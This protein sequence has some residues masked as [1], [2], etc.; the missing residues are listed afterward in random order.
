MPAMEDETEIMNAYTVIFDR[1]THLGPGDLAATKRLV[2][3][4]RPDLPP[5]L[6]VADFGC[7]VGASTLVLAEC[8][9]ES[10]VLALDS[11]APFI[12]RLETEA[13]EL[14]L[15]DRISAVVGDMAN[16]PPLDGVIGEFDLIWAESAIYNIGRAN[17]FACWR[18]LLKP[19]GWLVFSDIV[20]QCEPTDRSD[21]AAVFWAGEYPDMKTATGVMDELG[22]AGFSALDPVLVD[23]KAWS[24]YYEPLRE[25]LRLLRTKENPPQALETVIAE[26]EQ[27][28]DVYDCAGNE[29]AL[30]FFLARRAAK[31]NKGLE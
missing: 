13:D 25:R 31:S 17:A 11:H 20:W 5:A 4:L 8:L 15:G 27:E 14:G 23:R 16:P 28:I 26:L 22:S 19:D 1:L 9:P 30:A 10:R 6:R 21:K 3:R 29:V 12:E 2:E 7:G 24:N 18:P